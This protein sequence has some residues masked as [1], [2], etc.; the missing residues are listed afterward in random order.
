L[1]SGRASRATKRRCCH[2]AVLGAAGTLQN[3]QCVVDL[4]ASSV[5]GS[6]NNLALNVAVSFKPAFVGTKSIYM[7]AQNKFNLNSGYQTRGT[8]TP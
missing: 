2:S 5:T 4:S 1:L 6:G 8:W 7:W 3:T